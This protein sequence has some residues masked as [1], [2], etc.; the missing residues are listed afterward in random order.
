MS[1]TSR[2]PHPPG[3]RFVAIS[4]WAVTQWGLAEAAVLGL[5]DFLDRG[6]QTEGMPLAN[7]KRIVADLD[8]IVGRD[9]VDKALRTLVDADVL[10]VHKTTTPG[11]RNL[12]T[13]IDYC[14]HIEGIARILDATGTPDFRSSGNSQN[15]E[16]RQ[17][18]N[19][20]LKSGVPSSRHID[21]EAAAPRAPARG[22]ADAAAALPQAGKVRTVRASGIVTWCLSDPSAAEQIEQQHT[23]DEIRAAVAAVTATGKDPVPGLVVRAIAQQRGAQE[24]IQRR[25][26]AD[27]AHRARLAAQSTDADLA[28]NQ[29]AKQRGEQ[30]LAQ[31]RRNRSINP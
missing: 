13:R 31:L 17:L 9:V 16:S 22:S 20:V 19:S 4:R 27:A 23:P 24:A 11:A 21:I 28:A 6:Q 30:M 3:S 25:A 1:R 14:L 18:L 29:A 8:G 12:Q 7:R 15:Q 10:R 5:L 26:V 2:I